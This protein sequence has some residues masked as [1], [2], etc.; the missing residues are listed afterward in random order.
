MIGRVWTRAGAAA[1]LCAG[2]AWAQPAQDEPAVTL[3][4]LACG[5]IEVL[6]LNVFSDVDAYPG[7]T[8]TLVV[9]CFLIR[10]GDQHLLWDAG[11]PDSM[12]E[13]TAPNMSLRAP[14]A[15]LPQ[16]EA[17]GLAPE[18]IDYIGVSHGHIDHI[19]NVNAFPNAT[20]IIQAKEWAEFA[21]NPRYAP[22]LISGYAEGENVVLAQGDHDVF[23]DGAV[24]TLFT[25]GHTPG[26][27]SLLVRLENAGPVILSGDLAHFTENLETHGVMDFNVDRADTL[28]SFD[29]LDGLVAN[30]GARIIVQHDA[31]DIATLP[32]PPGYLD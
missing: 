31:D 26:H 11:L 10:H 3:T 18:D 32:A 5:E 14:R 1:M 22:D 9:T 7:R 17:L 8:K 30:L 6:N 28:A 4:P 13:I 20:L 23:G 16:L 19:G 25:P 21:D 24:V 2:G 29:R 15:L 27:Q 12:A